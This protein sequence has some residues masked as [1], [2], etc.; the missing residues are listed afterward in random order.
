MSPPFTFVD[1]SRDSPYEVLPTQKVCLGSDFLFRASQTTP[2]SSKRLIRSGD[3]TSPLQQNPTCRFQT[4]VA[5]V[6]R[7]RCSLALSS[8]ECGKE[9]R[10]F[11]AREGQPVVEVV[12]KVFP[13]LTELSGHAFR[14]RNPFLPWRP[15]WGAFCKNIGDNFQI[16]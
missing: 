4:P 5:R 7:H 16:L 8:Q 9:R 14:L 3:T 6:L 2:S 15:F 13:G 1:I 11:K 12:A 10:H